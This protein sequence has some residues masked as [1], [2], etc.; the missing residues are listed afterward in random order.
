VSAKFEL[1][2]GK[3]KEYATCWGLSSAESS[4]EIYRTK[5]GLRFDHDPKDG[6]CD[7]MD[8]AL[9]AAKINAILRCAV[10]FIWF[11]LGWSM[12][13]NLLALFRG[14]LGIITILGYG[15]F[16]MSILDLKRWLELKEYKN[17]GTIHGRRAH[18][19]SSDSVPRGQS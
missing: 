13:G 4:D 12:A 14:D 17:N 10:F 15:I 6:A 19:L 3:T 5:C 16:V 7:H 1:D 2:N 8:C 18:R 11:I 9:H